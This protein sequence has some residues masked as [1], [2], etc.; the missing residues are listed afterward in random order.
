MRSKNIGIR[1]EV[2]SNKT[3]EGD[4]VDVRVGIKSKLE[5][6]L[7]ATLLSKFLGRSIPGDRKTGDRLALFRCPLLPLLRQFVFVLTSRVVALLHRD[8]HGPWLSTGMI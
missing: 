8:T 7:T 3:V 2:L 5:V 1:L 4:K 6:D